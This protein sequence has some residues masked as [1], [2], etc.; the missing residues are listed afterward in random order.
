MVTVEWCLDIFAEM[1]IEIEQTQGKMGRVYI[2]S[3][4]EETGG[5]NAEQYRFC[6]SFDAWAYG[7]EDQAF[8]A[9]TAYY[10]ADG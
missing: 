9:E 8:F 1:A 2:D 3:D 5:V 10:V 4:D 6:T 7:F